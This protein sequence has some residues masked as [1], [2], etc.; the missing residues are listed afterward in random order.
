MQK[1]DI[2]I[3]KNPP[4]EIARIITSVELSSAGLP[5]WLITVLEFRFDSEPL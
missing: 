5:T 4:I 2:S 1:S 3:A